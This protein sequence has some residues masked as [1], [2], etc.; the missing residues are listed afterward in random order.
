V[1]GRARPHAPRRPW[2]RPRRP[3]TTTA[4]L[5]HPDRRGGH[6]PPGRRGRRGWHRGRY[7][8]RISGIGRGRPRPV[9]HGH[10]SPAGPRGHDTRLGRDHGHL[11]CPP[12]CDRPSLGPIPRRPLARGAGRPLRCPSG[13]DPGRPRAPAR[14]PGRLSARRPLGHPFPHR[15][16]GPAPVPP[17]RRRDRPGRCP[18]L[19][20]RRPAA[21]DQ[22][23]GDLAHRTPP[24]QRDLHRTG[25][26]RPAGDRH[27]AGRGPARGPLEPGH[28]RARHHRRDPL[29]PGDR[30]PGR[31][32]RPGWSDRP[33]PHRIGAPPAPDRHRVPLPC[34]AGHG[35]ARTRATRRRRAFLH[36]GRGLL[37][38]A[39]RWGGR[40]DRPARGPWGRCDRRGHLAGSGRGRGNPRFPG[41]RRLRR[42]HAV[43]VRG[44]GRAPTPARLDHS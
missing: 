7:S 34:P 8:G 22:L 23:A 16:R 31:C 30:G 18:P 11:P 6:G 39:G 33:D 36:P 12:G 13:R 5:E 1:L 40:A 10:L 21:P 42:H 3:G 27:T 41:P 32:A 35:R 20:A 43:L 38:A 19:P 28:D 4:R 44:V 24:H 37:A 17:P 14:H 29:L 15:R 25:H 2:G 9:R 26:R